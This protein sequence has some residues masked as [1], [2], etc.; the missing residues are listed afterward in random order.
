MLDYVGIVKEFH[1][2]FGQAAPD[3][4]TELDQKT[5]DLRVRLVLEE[6]LETV[7]AL[8]TPGEVDRVELA[9]GLADLIYVL[10]GT[11][12]SAG[13]RFSDITEEAFNF[14]EPNAKLANARDI[15]KADAIAA[16]GESV[17]L[18]KYG[19]VYKNDRVLKAGADMLLQDILAI[20]EG[21]N[22]PIETVFTEVH[23]SNMSKLGADGKPIRDATGKVVKGPN[24]F[25]PDIKKI[26]DA[27]TSIQATP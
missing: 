23:R 6:Y 24:F 16:M 15:N 3:T 12:A 19:L 9:D 13:A 4:E 14:F 27:H 8:S 22:I 11:L 26:L 1:L 18:V 7:N 21:Y 20:A 17:N 10:A 25:R 2:A 5:R